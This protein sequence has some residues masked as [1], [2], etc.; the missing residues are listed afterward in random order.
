MTLMGD[1]G[2]SLRH[3]E[4]FD[5]FK[6][7]SGTLDEWRIQK[8]LHDHKSE[9]EIFRSMVEKGNSSDNRPTDLYFDDGGFI[10]FIVYGRENYF[11]FDDDGQ[12]KD[13]PD[14]VEFDSVES[15]FNTTH[16]F[17]VEVRRSIREN[18]S[19]PRY[20]GMILD[21][22]FKNSLKKYDGVTLQAFND[23]LIN[24]YKS[25]H[26]FIDL[27]GGGNGMVKWRSTTPPSRNRE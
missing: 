4:K 18:K 1:W 26:G 17:D 12:L 9:L 14:D 3:A 21:E 10:G 22:F 7:A 15:V 25:V 11:K 13:I 19:L 8:T 23:G 2:M 20:G 16:L 24:Y 27:R 6:I 5:D